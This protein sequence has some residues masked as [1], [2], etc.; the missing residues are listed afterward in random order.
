MRSYSIASVDSSLRL[1]VKKVDNGVVSRYLIDHAPVG[2]ILLVHPP[3]GAFVIPSE[4]DG[5]F[6]LLGAGSG[7]GPLLSLAAEARQRHRT[8]YLH[9]A[10]RRDQELYFSELFNAW[11]GSGFHYKAYRSQEGE[12][13]TPALLQSAILPALGVEPA[14]AVYMLCGPFA[15]MRSLRITLTF[16]GI[17]EERIRVEQFSAPA[18]PETAI[19]QDFAG[20]CEA[21]WQTAAGGRSFPIH[22]GEMVLPAAEQ[23]GLALP[24]SC[25]GGVCGSCRALALKGKLAMRRNEVLAPADVKQGYFLTC[26]ALPLTPELEFILK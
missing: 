21:I 19:E 14:K 20:P 1:L 24:Y 2:T 10:A 16:L 11:T 18:L 26:T 17:P 22:V 23:A 9:H 15:W 3:K 6:V 7:I 12:R 25:R 4:L 13:I 8:A 5:P